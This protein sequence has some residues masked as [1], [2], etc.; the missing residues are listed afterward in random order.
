MTGREKS[1]GCVV[2]EDL[3]N[4]VPIVAT[5]GEKAATAIE[6]MQGR[7]LENGTA[8]RPKPFSTAHSSAPAQEVCM[9]QIAD[10][11]NLREAF[12]RVA[13]NRG[14]PGPDGRTIEDVRHGLDT[15]VVKLCRSLLNGSYR[16]G[17]IRRVFIPKAGGGERGLGIPNVVD[18]I[19]QQAIL[20]KLSPLYE[21]EFHNSSHGFRPGRSCH[22]AIA[23]AKQHVASGRSWVVD[24]D[25]EKF[26]DRV[27]HQRL[28][29]TLERRISDRRIVQVVARML[30][31]KVAMPN[32]VIVTTEEG[33]PQG[34]PLSPLLSNIVLN[35]LDWELERRRHR[36]VRYADDMNVYVQ[37]ERAGQRVFAGLKR[38]LEQRM[39]LQ[40]NASKSAVSR[41]RGRHFLGFSIR[42]NLAKKRVELD[43]SE[44]TRKRLR[45]RIQELTP[46]NWGRSLR[47]CIE[48][49]NLY[50]RGWAE[51]FGVAYWAG[52]VA[53]Y[54][55]GH[56]RRRLR[57]ILLTHWKKPATI[58]R[59][60]IQL[61]APKNYVEASV[62]SANQPWRRTMTLAVNYGLRN[63]HFARWGLLSLDELCAKRLLAGLPVPDSNP[64][65]IG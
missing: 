55:D 51:Y 30:R 14:A 22:T 9:E 59:Q 46:R 31:S 63:E 45:Q 43:V 60:L 4:Q 44:R 53:R 1:D 52:G 10:E 25:L 29:A 47:T 16:P 49:I 28:L 61:G 15:T 11:A 57:A 36:F 18:R 24:I 62:G 7:E 42:P 26:F 8:G 40:V 23:E 21:P 33:T 35:E 2:S 56:L 17:E 38:F 64:K 3:G 58:R 32:G 13:A 48:E 19:V 54:A 27:P 65:A 12:K 50:L 37:S 6:R 34:G 5:R 20:Q 39:R 41:P